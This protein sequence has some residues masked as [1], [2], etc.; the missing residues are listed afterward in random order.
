MFI[1]DTSWLVDVPPGPQA[2][3]R[4]EGNGRAASPILPGKIM[5][6]HHPYL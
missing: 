2:A 3:R 1:A 4:Q 6:K 5:L